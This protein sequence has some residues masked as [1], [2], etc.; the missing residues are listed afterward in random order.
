MNFLEEIEVLLGITE[1]DKFDWK[2]PVEFIILSFC[3]IQRANIIKPVKGGMLKYRQQEK[4][5]MLH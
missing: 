3:K 1:N 2:Y 4:S 5:K